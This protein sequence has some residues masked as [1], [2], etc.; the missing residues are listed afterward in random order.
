MFGMNIHRSSAALLLALGALATQSCLH[1]EDSP[2]CSVISVANNGNNAEA[3]ASKLNGV[4]KAITVRALNP[5]TLLICANAAT[6]M[7][8]SKAV[9]QLSATEPPAPAARPE[10]T[11]HSMRLFFNRNAT[12]IAKILDQ[13]YP[14]IKVQPLGSDTLIFRTTD[15]KQE[16]NIRELQRW[17]ALLDTPR[18]ELTLNIWSVQLSSKNLKDL[19]EESTQIGKVVSRHNQQLHDALERAWQ[20]LIEKRNEAGF[21]DTYFSDYIALRHQE[22]GAKSDANTRL[23][24]PTCG[25]DRYCLG[26]GEAFRPLRPALTHMLGVLAAAADRNIAD[27]FVNCLEGLAACSWNGR[28]ATA[29]TEPRLRPAV[30]VKR[31]NESE[32]A[33]DCES[34]DDEALTGNPHRGPSFACFRQ[35]LGESLGPERKAL[36][37]AAIADFL[38]QYKLSIMHPHE[39]DVYVYAT[40]AQELDA[41]FDP[42]LVAF[43]RDV[44]VFL[45]H[46]QEEVRES[47]AHIKGIGFASNGTVTVRTISG[48]DAE[49]DT[50]TQNS[51]KN[52]PPPLV[53]DFVN[54]L[55]VAEK[56]DPAL[57]QANLPK[58]AADALAAFLQSGQSST[59][60][61]GRALNLKIS[62]VSLQGASAA[63]LKI[64]LESKDDDKPQVI[65]PDGSAKTDTT[66]RVSQQTVDTNVRVDTLKLFEVS[67]FSAALSRGREPIPLLPP[68]V[69]LP[70]IGSFI[71]LKL[72]PS[73]VYHRSFAI[74]SAVVVPT[75][76]DLLTGLRFRPDPDQDTYL[77]KK[78]RDF[79]ARKLGCIVALTNPREATSSAVGEECGTLSLGQSPESGS[80]ASR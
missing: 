15:P 2:S 16:D 6:T 1:G 48:T 20:Y 59:V 43:N 42:L 4:I 21:F 78:I 32:A 11:S 64:H 65:M 41:Q 5:K 38:F 72:S 68:F 44:A 51:F 54:Q 77:L 22:P 47:Q 25:T 73:T 7:E 13:V 62:P 26:Y 14:D 76:G 24:L 57:L 29:Q 31:N 36:L 8:L 69:E 71:H 27:H 19:N 39:Y 18:P 10:P 58:H 30:R 61:M 56:N 75:S 52:T 80:V 45:K 79:H 17:V 46:L 34:R 49:V 60:S 70:Y 12:D 28:V 74:V 40:S 55:G 37:R 35:Q 3:I 63:E 9:A 50:T 66:D 33:D 23:D 53:Q 67:S